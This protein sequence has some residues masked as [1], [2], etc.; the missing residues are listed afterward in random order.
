V[1]KARLGFVLLAL[2]CATPVAFSQPAAPFAAVAPALQTFVDTGEVA[3]VVTLIATKDKV[4][5]PRFRRRPGRDC[6]G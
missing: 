2:V 1:M 4:I 3:G 5:H 6:T